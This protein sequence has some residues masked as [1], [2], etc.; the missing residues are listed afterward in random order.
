MWFSPGF[1]EVAEPEAGDVL[2]N[3][4]LL[5][6]V[7]IKRT[8]VERLRRL[9]VDLFEERSKFSFYELGS[10]LVTGRI[11]VAR[12]TGSVPAILYIDGTKSEYDLIAYFIQIDLSQNTHR[13][14]DHSLSNLASLPMKPLSSDD[15]RF[16]CTRGV[17]CFGSGSVV[18]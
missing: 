17:V 15:M 7:D 16:S 2:H 5:L 8:H 14:G 18:V 4:E 9:T 13:L 11:A 12:T 10:R 6:K 1:A 3:W